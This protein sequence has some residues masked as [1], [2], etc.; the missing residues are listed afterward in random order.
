MLIQ[1]REQF[2]AARTT[3]LQTNYI[4]VDTETSGL[5]FHM[6]H[7]IIGIST[8]CKLPGNEQ[9]QLLC[10]F[11]FRHDPKSMD[12]F[13][14]SENLPIEWMKEL[15]TCFTRSDVELSFHNFKF[16]AKM[17]RKEGITIT[18]DT[19]VWDTMVMSHMVDENGVHSLKGLAAELWGDQVREEETFTKA[20]VRKRGGWD[21]TSAAEMS[22]Y[23]CKDAE[24][25]FDLK[26][27]LLPELETQEL[28]PLWESQEEPFLHVLLDME[29]EGIEVDLEMAS[30]RSEASRARMRELEDA[31]GF[32]PGKKDA[33]AHRLFAAPPEGLGLIPGAL[34]KTSSEEFPQGIPVMDEPFLSRHLEHA[35]VRNVLEYRGLVKAN[36]TWWKGFPEKADKAGRI[37][38]QYS[39]GIGKE[40]FGTVTGRL[41]SSWPNVQQM[42]RDESTPVKKLLLPPDQFR[43]Y[44]F[45]YSQIELR[46]AACYADDELYLEAF[47]N[48]EDPHQATA[49]AIGIERQPAK[50]ASYCILYGGAADT[51]KGTIERLTFQETGQFIEFPIERAEEILRLYYEVHPNLK[52]K[53]KEAERVARRRGYVNLWTGRRRHFLKEEPWTHR[54]AFNSVLQGGAA[55]ILKHTML[56]LASKIS[57]YKAESE[58]GTAPYRMVTQIHDSLWFEVS[59]HFREQW[60]AEIQEIME[61]PG[62]NGRF[63]IPFPVDMK[64]VNV[65]K[66]EQVWTNSSPSTLEAL[67]DGPGFEDNGTLTPWG[68]SLFEKDQMASSTS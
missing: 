27:Q 16:D 17:L 52:S 12:L 64:L 63:P 51:L 45:D 55:E 25:T 42:P 35:L 44:E 60:L 9:Y 21:K 10:Y 22:D 1:T 19:K 14:L 39:T 8:A 7:H 6:G 20:L 47:R 18:R 26:D 57:G 33:L 53:P 32:D 59:N 34:N 40:K 48:G 37:H 43:M 50:H 24:M 15:A 66:R 46:L 49:E 23:A 56:Q 65:S 38:P 58:F 3:L 62:V 5:H 61:W 54:K 68:Q 29:W 41:S 13:T 36:S 11:P 31:M 30:E 28:T 2:I 4:A 67:L